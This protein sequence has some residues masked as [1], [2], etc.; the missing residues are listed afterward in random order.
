M[1]FLW[2]GKSL[3]HAWGASPIYLLGKYYLVIRPLTP[4]RM[5]R[6]FLGRLPEDSVAFW[7]FDAPIN[8]ETKRDIA[9]YF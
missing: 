6:Y 2:I 5:A 3:C 9:V 1:D 8:S 4:K 7:D